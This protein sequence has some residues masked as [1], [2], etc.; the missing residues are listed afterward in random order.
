MIIGIN[1]M[2]IEHN[3][4]I[5]DENLCGWCK[6]KFFNIY[7]LKRHTEK[8]K[9]KNETQTKNYQ[10]TIQQLEKTNKQLSID[11]E[12]TKSNLNH[13]INQIELYKEQVRTRDKEIEF[14][15]EKIEKLIDKMNISSNVINVYNNDPNQQ[16]M[17]KVVQE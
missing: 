17:I 10:K 15:K 14:L 11:I 2:D 7:S 4:Y 8:C 12:V 9:S 6:K 5:T 3:N 16:N 13:S 1:I